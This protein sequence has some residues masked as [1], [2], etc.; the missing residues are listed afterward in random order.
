VCRSCRDS[1]S[2]QRRDASTAAAVAETPSSTSIEPESPLVAAPLPAYQLR[3]GV[4]LSRPPQITRDLHP[5]EKAFFMYQRRLNERTALPFIKQFYFKPGTPAAD[6][7]KHRMKTRRSAARDIG[8]Y[9]ATRKHAW[10]DELVVGAPESE[11]AHQIEALLQDAEAP[12]VSAEEAGTGMKKEPI[13]RPMPRVTEAD[14]KGD[15]KSLDRSLQRSLYL[16]VKNAAGRWSFPQTQLLPRESLH[17]VYIAFHVRCLLKLTDF[18]AS[19]QQSV[20]SSNPVAST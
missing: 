11:P 12:S 1:I 10:N 8:M 18:V 14:E 16:V 6:D 15:R 7:W 9:S 17:K 3:A 2:R 13:E 20:P 4:V 19:R 5:F